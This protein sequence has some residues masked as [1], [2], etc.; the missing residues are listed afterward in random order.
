MSASNSRIMRLLN[1]GNL[2]EQ[3]KMEDYVAVATGA[4]R[5]A[6][7][8][9]PADFPEG[10]RI[11]E[12]IDEGYSRRY[13]ESRRGGGP[14]SFFDR[15]RY[16]G[17][18]ALMNP[19]RYKASLLREAFE[20]A[21]WE[22]SNYRAAR[23]WAAELGLH[24]YESQVRPSLDEMY[25]V[26]DE[27][28]V[29]RVAAFISR[30]EDIRREMM[31]QVRRQGGAGPQM[32]FMPE[33]KSPEYLRLAGD[34]LGYPECCVEGYIED[35]GADVDSALR[36]SNQLS[37]LLQEDGDGPAV[38]VAST[39]FF[40]SSFYPCEPECESAQQTGES[41]LEALGET[42][43]RLVSRMSRVFQANMDY[44]K[45]YP[46]ILQRRRKQMMSQYMGGVPSEEQE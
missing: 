13:Y 34:L 7:L 22:H 37:E 19:L 18:R 23:R 9:I 43:E 3:V 17:M 33:E 28:T 20:E 25:V 21:V 8:W 31:Q 10:D 4:R 1:D 5:A 35:A 44:V 14:F 46:E 12:S 11:R 42:D 26:R 2:Q 24:I 40:A 27:Q 39:A 16:A 15:I 38:E 29:G 36:S 32:A 41:M 6:V 45:K 30:R